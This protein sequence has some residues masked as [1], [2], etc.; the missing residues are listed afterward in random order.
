MERRNR[1]ELRGTLFLWNAFLSI[2]SIW[3][4]YRT[5]PELFYVLTNFGFHYSACI[6]G[7]S[8][9]DNRIGG[10]WIWMFTLSKV[11]ELGDTVFIVL[12][13]QPLMFLH[14]YHHV[15]VLIYSWYSY[16]DYIATARWFISMNYCVHSIMYSYYAL[17]S[18]K[19][20][21]P[22][23]VSMSITVAQLAQMIM[24]SIVNLW[25]FYMKQN[26]YEC[27]P[28]YD[29]IKLSL[30]MYTS[31]FVLFAHFFKRAYFRPHRKVSDAGVLKNSSSF[32]LCK[33]EKQKRA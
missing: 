30:L 12:R 32:N 29:N 4:V 25:A 16:P 9:L 23:W 15:T 10:F 11:P 18:L 1:F 33:E 27:H 21:V 28:P 13:K 5:L 3:G 20:P 19:V 24:G 26:G 2:F 8:F 31:Y 6:P 14:W 22:K 7:P 17:K